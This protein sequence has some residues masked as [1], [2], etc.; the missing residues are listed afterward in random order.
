MKEQEIWHVLKA[1][2]LRSWN[3][4]EDKSPYQ[5]IICCALS[6]GIHAV[7]VYRWGQ[8]TMSTT[9]VIRPPLRLVALILDCMIR[10]LWGIELHPTTRIGEGFYIGHF[11]GIIISPQAVIGKNFT[12]S[13]GVSIGV[14]GQGD[15]YG[16]PTIGDFVYVAP[17][18][19]L[20]GKIRI[21]NNVKIGANAVVH[22]NIQDNAVAVLDPGF[23][24]IS[25]EGNIKGAEHPA[26]ETVL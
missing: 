16:A 21:G 22:K 9:G 19:K 13:Q 18:A 14:S 5:K 4:L 25:S 20:F 15:K 3:M 1:D 17:G 8:W 6:P 26:D 2:V 11:G 24:I 10:I 12:C 7:V 23:R